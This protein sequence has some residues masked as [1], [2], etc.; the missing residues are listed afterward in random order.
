MPSQYGAGYKYHIS[1][2][3]I[4]TYFET[5]V[6]NIKT[7]E[8]D[9]NID[10]KETYDY[11]LNYSIY[12]VRLGY[13]FYI[14]SNNTQ[15]FFGAD[16]FGQYSNQKYEYERNRIYYYDPYMS[17]WYN[18]KSEIEYYGY[19]LG[20]FMGVRLYLND[21]ISVSTETR[22]DVILFNQKGSGKYS[23]NNNPA[24]TNKEMSSGG[25]R[26]NMRPLGL[27]SLNISF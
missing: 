22:F 25:L 9:E 7:N 11:L 8:V 10:Y 1:K 12:N 19:G 4:R 5:G 14:G 13:E 21:M 3:A 23:S 17:N 16:L 2:G 26:M 15:F 24:G 27:F 20:P 18:N 6:R